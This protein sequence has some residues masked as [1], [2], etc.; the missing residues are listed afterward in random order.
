MENIPGIERQVSMTTF[1]VVTVAQQNKLTKRMATC[2]NCGFVLDISE[3]A[4]WKHWYDFI[5]H[6]VQIRY[7]N[8][9]INCFLFASQEIRMRIRFVFQ[10]CLPKRHNRQNESRMFGVSE[11][12]RYYFI[13]IHGNT[14]YAV[15]QEYSI[16]QCQQFTNG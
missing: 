1:G 13:R 6:S 3:L 11:K 14:S 7:S 12:F 9:I 16:E 15:W 10:V 5:D 8:S 2:K 4:M